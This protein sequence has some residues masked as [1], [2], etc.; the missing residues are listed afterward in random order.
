MSMDQAFFKPLGGSV[1]L[2]FQTANE[3]LYLD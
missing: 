2:G 1:G 3:N